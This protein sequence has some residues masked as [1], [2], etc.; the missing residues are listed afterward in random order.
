MSLLAA[1]ADTP[2]GVRFDADRFT[3]PFAQVLQCYE[4]DPHA[5]GS[6]AFVFCETEEEGAQ[7]AA[8]R[9]R[10]LREPLEDYVV[11]G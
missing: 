9:E 6:Y 11:N 7:G 1:P 3:A 2:T 5:V 4:F 8:D 10:L